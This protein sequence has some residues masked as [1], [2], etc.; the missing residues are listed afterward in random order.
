MALCHLRLLFLYL[1]KNVSALCHWLLHRYYSLV[2]LFLPWFCW[3]LAAIFCNIPYLLAPC[4][5]F[6]CYH[7][8]LAAIS[9]A[10]GS[11]QG[12]YWLLV[13]FQFFRS[14]FYSSDDPSVIMKICIVPIIPPGWLYC[15]DHPSWVIIV[16][17]IPPG[18]LFICSQ[19]KVFGLSFGPIPFMQTGAFLPS[20]ADLFIAGIPRRWLLI[21][22]VSLL[23]G[24]LLC[25]R[26]RQFFISISNLFPSF[27]SHSSTN[28]SYRSSQS[29]RTSVNRFHFLILCPRSSPSENRINIVI[30][31]SPYSILF[32]RCHRRCSRENGCLINRFV[33]HSTSMIT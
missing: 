20:R 32:E 21:S 27:L 31:F 11:L 7:W 4:S 28:S 10:L 12:L 3:L 16:P 22:Q 14:P 17:I 25:R 19:F 29:N 13:V 5:N 24:Q 9:I 33:S 6:P 23:G 15:T 2:S 30:I 8:L 26:P 1:S 18:W